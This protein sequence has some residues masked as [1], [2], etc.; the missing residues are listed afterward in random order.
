[1]NPD[2]STVKPKV[3]V[4]HGSRQTGELLLNRMHKLRKKCELVAPTAPFAS[5]ENPELKRWWEQ[6]YRG[7]EDSINL[8]H[9]TWKSGHFSGIL[10]F[11]QGGLLAHFLLRIHQNNPSSFF[12]GLQ[13]AILVAS[14]A[15]QNLPRALES[16]GCGTVSS[17]SVSVPTLHVWGT[18]DKL[19]LPEHSQSLSEG[20]VKKMTLIH[21]GGH[22]VPMKA[23]HVQEY[24]HFMKQHTIVEAK[25][26]PSTEEPND[27]NKEL[28]L[29]EL[30]AL[31]AIFPEELTCKS[32]QF[33]LE[34]RIRLIPT[35]PNWPP[36]EI[37][38][39]IRYPSQYPT[40]SIPEMKLEHANNTM[41]FPRHQQF[42]NFL[43]DIARQ[44]ESMPCIMSCVYG[45]Q[46]FFD[47]VEMQETRSTIGET[48]SVNTTE[49]EDEFICS[50]DE[51]KIAS[52]EGLEIASS[53][54]SDLQNQVSKKTSSSF[55]LT[56]G[57]VGKPSAGKSTF[58][59]TATAFARQRHSTSLGAAMA[60]HPFTTIDPNIGFALIP[61]PHGM[62]PEDSANKC[63]IDVA[64]THGRDH[65]GRR[66]IPALLKDV[67]GLVPGAYQGRG[68]GNQFLAD[69]TDADV[70]IHVL[71]ATGLSD[72]EGN[73]VGRDDNRASN[74]LKDLSWIRYELME[75]VYSNLM[76]KWE[77]V[78]RKGRSKLGDMFSGY[79]QPPSVTDVI[80]LKVEQF[81]VLRDKPNALENLD[82]WTQ[83]DVVRL[84]S[85]FLGVRFP[86]ILS[87]NKSDVPS[88]TKHIEKIL[89]C[90]PIDGAHVAIPVSAKSE[91]NFLKHYVLKSTDTGSGATSMK[92]PERVWETL[93]KALESLH[94]VF[95]FPVEDFTS[96]RPLSGLTRQALEHASLPTPGMIACLEGARG[97][98]PTHWNSDLQCYSAIKDARSSLSLRDVI[99]FKTGSTVEDA[100]VALKR[101]GALTGDFVRAEAAKDIGD[102]PKPVAKCTRLGIETR[103][104]KIMTTRRISWQ[105]RKEAT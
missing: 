100:F 87:L 10:G 3:L 53:I 85:A 12:E 37:T 101:L 68:K 35:G 62:C 48:N 72:A 38:L 31:Q 70:L 21:D 1:M 17:C 16:F 92:P 83:A 11:S 36:H 15:C 88:S 34:Y 46:D 67:A 64:C 14:P 95:I 57:L 22:C 18:D 77:T 99:L 6:D 86:M 33:P 32:T 105:Y 23:A 58:F 43:K 61:I 82:T 71:D 90:L 25:V 55:N 41:Q 8:L 102:A 50:Q 73:I 84:A 56:I 81:M 30:E 91:M 44:N 2:S 45:A 98:P 27:E 80:L 49:I 5:V 75:W 20:Y 65:Q 59:N 93:S 7:L 69:L 79:G 40:N 4:L 78:K 19:V 66:L 39:H 103:I 29:D 24:I 74:P 89:S 76:R 47:Q 104:L 94:P 13:W 96:Y 63:E 52:A 26:A 28:Q 97:G 54:R 42:L 60:S 51:I 9:D